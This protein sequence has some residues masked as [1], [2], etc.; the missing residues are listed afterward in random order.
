MKAQGPAKAPASKPAELPKAREA[1]AAPTL[2]PLPAPRIATAAAPP[3]PP[4]PGALL[5]DAGGAPGQLVKADFLAELRAA[6]LLAAE[7]ELAGTGWTAQHC[8]Y[9]EYWFAYYDRRDARDVEAALR[10]YVPEARGVVSAAEYLAPAIARVRTAV[11]RWR[12]SGEIDAPPAV[13]P[14]V[15]ETIAALGPGLP[16]DGA[17]RTRFEGA[18]GA[19]LSA[20]RIHADAPGARAADAADAR[21]FAAGDHIAFAGGEF[22]PGTVVGDALLAHEIAHTQ[23]QT[24]SAVASAPSLEHDADTAAVGTLARLWSW[25][26]V[27]VTTPARSSGLQLQRCPQSRDISDI[28]FDGDKVPQGVYLEA[29]PELVERD[30]KRTALVGQTVELRTASTIENLH[31]PSFSWVAFTKDPKTGETHDASHKHVVG[32]EAFTFDRVGEWHVRAGFE[33]DGKN[34]AIDTTVWVV[35]PDELA[36][37]GAEAQASETKDTSDLAKRGAIAYK[38]FR[39]GL[40]LKTLESF[41][42]SKDQY[43]S[44]GSFI[45][46]SSSNPATDA[47]SI[48]YTLERPNAKATAFQWHRRPMLHPEMHATQTIGGGS[49][50]DL[51]GGT[52]KKIE[53]EYPDKFEITCD[54]F[55]ANGT[56][57]ETATYTQLT[58]SER[59]YES[60]KKWQDYLAGVDAKIKRLATRTLLPAAFINLATGEA[61]PIAL[62]TGPDADDPKKQIVLDLTPNIGPTVYSGDTFDEAFSD[63]KDHAEKKYP[64]GSFHVMTS[65]IPGHKDTHFKGGKKSWARRLSELLNLPA[66]GLTVA[67]L[68]A[69][70]FEN[71]P[72]AFRFFTAAAGTG[73]VQSA[74]NIYDRYEYGEQDALGYFVDIVG[75][76]LSVLQFGTGYRAAVAAQAAKEAGTSL[77]DAL[78][79]NGTTRFVAWVETGLI[80]STAFLI[81]AESIAALEQVR[82]DPRLSEGEREDRIAGLLLQLVSQGV[83]FSLSAKNL[84]GVEAAFAARRGVNL[85]ALEKQVLANLDSKAIENLDKIPDAEI[86]RVVA[87][88]IESPKTTND[89]LASGKYTSADELDKAVHPA[90]AEPAKPVEEP[91]KPVE[92]PA[93]PAEEPAKPV[94]EPVKPEQAPPTPESTAPT[95]EPTHEQVVAEREVAEELEFE[96]KRPKVKT[97]KD[98]AKLKRQGPKVPRNAKLAGK[99]RDYW[100]GRVRDL[101]AELATGKIESKPPLPYEDYERFRTRFE[102]GNKFQGRASARLKALQGQTVSNVLDLS[103]REIDDEVGMLSASTKTENE[104][105]LAAQAAAKPGEKVVGPGLPRADHVIVATEDLARPTSEPIEIE[106]ISDKSRD[107][108][109]YGFTPEA[110]EQLET[111]V[112]NDA[113][114]L[115]D[116]YGGDVEIRSSKFGGKLN[117]RV[118]RVRKLTLLY[119]A[120]ALDATSKAAIRKAAEQDRVKVLFSDEIGIPGSR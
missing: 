4:L 6:V 33:L 92:E 77:A 110:P 39:L 3:A 50:Y 32:G 46:S 43:T 93:K 81:G 118:V 7:Q 55:D 2:V 113:A 51:G 94:E 20:V 25:A 24:G 45:R 91:A 8:P 27:A 89:A 79:V 70:L 114:E 64:K 78:V 117:G 86:E 87:D 119:D 67:G 28:Y 9:I 112:R 82:T 58:Q 30:N 59:E 101:E 84:A 83:M 42:V 57:L 44:T 38:R 71:L 54:Q 10:R 106:V 109:E 48:T 116:K 34:L 16:L 1:A 103:G 41:G 49:A 65:I 68:V 40:A 115:R 80:G 37:Q 5:V 35:D 53:F 47:N 88:V 76:A 61:M 19:D 73:A 108:L 14:A 100:N 22:A 66:I 31:A 69:L 29:T 98:L 62:F 102:R 74:A 52:T 95:P 90:P 99:Y 85:A 60:T 96:G 23:Q 11:R 18:V 63:F 72:W 15:V 105:R 56:L 107:P 97:A 26:K 75:L 21:A 120:E 111:Q 36:K 104:R 17:T 13:M 12:A